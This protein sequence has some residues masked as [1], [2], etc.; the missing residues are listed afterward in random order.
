MIN[1]DIEDTY[2]ASS[3]DEDRFEPT[4][5]LITGAEVLAREANKLVD[6]ELG[7]DIVQKPTIWEKYRVQCD[8]TKNSFHES[9][10]DQFE[11]KGYLSPKQVD[12][13]R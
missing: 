13:L 12:A 10:H 9:L 2:W 7:L 4:I 8:P 6:D 1:F 11:R 3:L 5:Y